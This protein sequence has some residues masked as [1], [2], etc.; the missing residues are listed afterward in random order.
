M[1][2]LVHIDLHYRVKDTDS[3]QSRL[4]GKASLGLRYYLSAAEMNKLEETES[5][6][7]AGKLAP[8]EKRES[9]PALFV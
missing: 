5:L 3:V 4:E 2:L 7:Y 6:W 1:K 8:G 9:K